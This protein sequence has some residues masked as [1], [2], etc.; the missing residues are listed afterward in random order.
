MSP[1]REGVPTWPYDCTT[2]RNTLVSLPIF[3]LYSCMRFLASFA[4]SCVLSTPSTSRLQHIIYHIVTAIVGGVHLNSLFSSW[5]ARPNKIA[6][7]DW[8]EKYRSSKLTHNVCSISFDLQ[9][10]IKVNYNTFY[11]A[12][13][14]M[15]TIPLLVGL[16]TFF[17]Q[18]SH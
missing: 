7:S 6:E 10:W 15:P 16:S 14:D 2:K 1:V 8:I 9:T 5:S 12:S 17:Y 11:L 18:M 13:E 3:P 4:F